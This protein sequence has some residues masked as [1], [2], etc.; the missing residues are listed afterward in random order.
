MCP[1]SQ[2][3]VDCVICLLPINPTATTVQQMNRGREM[4]YFSFTQHCRKNLVNQEP[5]KQNCPVLPH[6]HHPGTKFQ[7]LQRILNITLLMHSGMRAW[8]MSVDQYCYR[9]EYSIAT[10]H[11]DCLEIDGLIKINWVRHREVP[12]SQSF[13]SI[14]APTDLVHSWYNV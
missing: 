14:E 3:L 1:M 10:A 9:I 4:K 11:L 5:V 7:V 2:F 12:G 8:Q 6:Q 13:F